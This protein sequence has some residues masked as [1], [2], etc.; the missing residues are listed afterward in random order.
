[1]AGDTAQADRLVAAARTAEVQYVVGYMKR[2]D[3]GVQ[4]ARRLLQA[5][6]SSGE[7]GP[8]LLARAHCF[9]GDSYCNAYGHVVT[10]E[11][12]VYADP[13]WPSAPADFS[14]PQAEQYARYLNCFSHNTNLLRYLFDATPS[15][16]Y[17]RLAGPAG[18]LAV[19]D[20]GAFRATLETGSTSARGW[21][22]VTEVFFADGRLVLRTPPP[23]LRNVP[24]EVE[25]YRAGDE[26]QICRPQLPWSWSFR[27]QAEAFVDDIRTGA[28]SLS[29]GSDAREDVHLI[30]TMW[31]RQ[32]EGS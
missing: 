2:Y 32:E 22:E 31:R 4:E 21:D 10:S 6:R 26:Q 29:P 15:V 19:L 20:F 5:L 25:L 18:G 11:S 24:A 8:V 12:P 3:A 28:E 17:A 7:L 13:G 9:M 30:E 23:L 27:R 16:E 1:M 14:V